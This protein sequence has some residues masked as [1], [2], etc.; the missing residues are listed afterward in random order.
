MIGRAILL[1]SEVLHVLWTG[2]DGGSCLAPRVHASIKIRDCS[3]GRCNVRGWKGIRR[4]WFQDLSVWIFSLTRFRWR[5]FSCDVAGVFGPGRSIRTRKRSRRG[6]TLS[7]WTR[8]R[9]RCSRRRGEM[10]DALFTGVSNGN[11]LSLRLAQ[12]GIKKKWDW[13]TSS[14]RFVNAVHA[15]RLQIQSKQTRI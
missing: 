5:W 9:R 15:T 10:N 7:T 2:F 11:K 3:L 1:R 4:G 8:T 14:L 6:L 12:Y 13:R